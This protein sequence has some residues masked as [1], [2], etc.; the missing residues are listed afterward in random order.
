L[1]GPV[2]MGKSSAVTCL[3]GSLL[4]SSPQLRQDVERLGAGCELVGELPGLPCA[5]SWTIDGQSCARVA[6]VLEA[7]AMLSKLRDGSLI[8]WAAA[9]QTAARGCVPAAS[10]HLI[11]SGS[12]S[13]VEQSIGWLALE[14]G[15]NVRRAAA[16]DIAEVLV[17][18]GAALCSRKPSTSEEFL[19]GLCAKDVLFNRAAH[20][21]LSGA[22]QGALRQILPDSAAGAVYAAFPSFRRLYTHVLTERV[23]NGCSHCTLS[24][25]RVGNQRLGPAKARKIRSL[26]ST[27]A[28]ATEQVT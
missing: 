20:K 9:L 28:E 7:T 11:V 5:A 3:S 21:S 4:A 8:R 14:L 13:G 6:V 1:K 24:D 25:L 26:F 12:A 27:S 23:A 22:W 18:Y 17:A 10:P 16:G 19:H 15:L 2:C